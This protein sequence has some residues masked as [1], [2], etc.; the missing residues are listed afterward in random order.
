[1]TIRGQFVEKQLPAKN[2]ESGSDFEFDDCYYA[3]L[4]WDMLP[5]AED[6]E[7]V[8]K[9]LLVVALPKKIS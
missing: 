3:E 8:Y 2:L 4:Y 9:I 7:K 1:L 6:G 5:D